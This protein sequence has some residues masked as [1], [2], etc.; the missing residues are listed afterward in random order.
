MAPRNKTGGKSQKQLREEIIEDWADVR[1][2]IDDLQQEWV[3]RQDT[4]ND[5]SEL[6]ASRHAKRQDPSG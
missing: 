5:E 1:R 4:A 3:D 2:W 6:K